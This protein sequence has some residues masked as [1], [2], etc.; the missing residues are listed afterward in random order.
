MNYK[1]E[2]WQSQADLCGSPNWSNIIVDDKRSL[3]RAGTI[4]NY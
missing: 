3:G 4:Y 2:S 1:K